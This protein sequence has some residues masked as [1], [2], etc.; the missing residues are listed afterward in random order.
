MVIFKNS[1][2]ISNSTRTDLKIYFLGTIMR[3]WL[4]NYRID[5]SARLSFPRRRRVSS[6]HDSRRRDLIIEEE[7]SVSRD[8]V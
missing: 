5:E 4:A 6:R 7:R 3:G 2:S 8:F 1:R